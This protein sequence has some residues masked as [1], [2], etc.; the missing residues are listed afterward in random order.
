MREYKLSLLIPVYNGSKFLPNC[1]NSILKQSYHNFE[2]VIC[3]DGSKD[4]SYE[5]I[6]EFQRKDNRIKVFSRDNKGL[7]YTRLD[8]LKHCSGDYVWFIDCDDSICE[9]AL[10]RINQKLNEK[11]VDILVV[12]YVK[13]Y[14]DGHSK[15]VQRKSYTYNL[16]EMMKTMLLNSEYHNAFTKVLRREVA[17]DNMIEERI[18]NINRRINMGEDLIW[19]FIWIKKAKSVA[20]LSFVAY[21]Y[22][23]NTTSMSFQYSFSNYEDFIFTRNYIYMNYVKKQWTNQEI[24]EFLNF[25]AWNLFYRIGYYRK[26]TKYSH[27]DIAMQLSI[28]KKYQIVLEMYTLASKGKLRFPSNIF[29]TTSEKESILFDIIINIYGKLI[30]IKRKL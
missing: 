29:C 19:S 7:F 8:L 23:I 6:K 26:S 2:I 30:E 17:Y 9:S 3:D 10:Q 14:L 18:H 16:E 27:K 12:D 21:I 11:S 15:T 25:F 28:A 22:M 5:V 1:I 13:H 4:D 24:V 20:Y